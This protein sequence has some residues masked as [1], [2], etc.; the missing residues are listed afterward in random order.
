MRVMGVGEASVGTR[1][2]DTDVRV[3]GDEE[4]VVGM[5]GSAECGVGVVSKM[6]RREMSAV[7]RVGVGD[8]MG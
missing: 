6:D 8:V 4:V 7:I 5:E 3:M 1:R 2:G